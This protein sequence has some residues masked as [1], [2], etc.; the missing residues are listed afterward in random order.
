MIIIINTCK[1]FR[2][3]TFADPENV[4]RALENCPHTLDGRTIDPK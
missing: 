2:F 1:Q 3:V 4:K